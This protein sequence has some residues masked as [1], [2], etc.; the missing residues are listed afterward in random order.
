MGAV[1]VGDARAVAREARAIHMQV[2]QMQMLD[3]AAADCV[4]DGD[5][6]DTAE[7]MVAALVEATQAQAL[8]DM[9]TAPRGGGGRKRD[10]KSGRGGGQVDGGRNLGQVFFF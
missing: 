8:I 2:Q 4:E 10:G 3:E 5:M 1:G 9:P 7:D 6:R